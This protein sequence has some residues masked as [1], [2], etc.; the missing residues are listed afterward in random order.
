MTEKKTLAALDTAVIGGGVSGLYAAWRLARD[1]DHAGGIALFEGG[2]RLGGRLWS[3][4]MKSEKAIPAELGGMFFSDAQTL[5]YDLCTSALSLETT[6]ITPRPD[7]AYLRGKRFRIADFDKPDV[8]PYNLA[9]EE[10]GKPYHDLIF[11]ALR[12]IVPDLDAHWPLNSQGSIAETVRYLRTVKFEGRALHH[13]G[14]WNLLSKVISNEAFLCLRDVVSSF[15]LFSNWNAHDAVFSFLQDLTGN[16]FRLTQG[17]E[18]LPR[19]LARDL[20]D[21]QVP[22]RTN[23]RLLGIHDGADGLL[24]LRFDGGSGETGISARRV[25]LA[26]PRLAIESLQHNGIPFRSGRFAE[27]LNAVESV[28]ACKIFLTFAEPWWRRVP[29]GPGVIEKDTFALSHTDLPMRQCYYLGVDPETGEGLLLASYGDA[30]AVPFWSALMSASGRQPGLRARVPEAAVREILRQL[31]EM[32]GTEV[33]APNDAVFVDWTRPP[34][35]GGWH[36][37]QPGWESWKVMASLR[38]PD[39][40]LGI[41]VCGEAFCAYQS[42]VEGALTSAE[43]LLQ[44]EFGLGA[45]H[46]LSSTDCLAPY[47]SQPDHRADGSNHHVGKPE[48][49]SQKTGR[50][51]AGA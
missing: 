45:P 35:G 27:A 11:L 48:E 29:E 46:W 31:G 42:W 23:H 28:P 39:P 43:V 51:S 7:F 24:Q 12:R 13:W 16:W 20:T 36:A 22:V 47:F 26:L 17:Y 38:R 10:R 19:R 40:E 15:S 2:D 1:T 25:I 41:H 37:W 33:P 50:G 9:E 8:L 14:F 34:F 21:L 3:I 18:Q 5:V 30:Q 44:E 32:H 6:P 49:L 4:G